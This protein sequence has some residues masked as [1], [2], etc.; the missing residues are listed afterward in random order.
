MNGTVKTTCYVKDSAGKTVIEARDGDRV[1]GNGTTTIT[2]L[3]RAG[4][5]KVNSLC[6]LDWT[7]NVQADEVTPPPD[8]TGMQNMRLTDL[9]TGQSWD[10]VRKPSV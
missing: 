4:N 6:Y 3:T 8:P 9:D 7:G 5:V 10:F 2:K 1:E